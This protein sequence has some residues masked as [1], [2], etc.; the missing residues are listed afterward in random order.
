[1]DIV[2]FAPGPELHAMAQEHIR[3][4][5]A[6]LAPQLADG[7]YMNFLEGEEARQRTREAFGAEK[8]ERLRAIKAEYD[9]ENLFR[10][11]YDISPK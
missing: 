2:A 6:S 8:Y 3:Q 7:A 4:F 5:K 9:P 1:M 11:G 10:F